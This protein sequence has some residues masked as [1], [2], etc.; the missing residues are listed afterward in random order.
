LPG[1]EPLQLS[2]VDH[3]GP[4]ENRDESPDRVD[5]HVDDVGIEHV[6]VRATEHDGTARRPLRDQAVA[7]VLDH[8]F[9]D[10]LVVAGRPVGRVDHR[11]IAARVADHHAELAGRERVHVL[12]V[13]V[14]QRRHW[15]RL[16]AHM[17][18]LADLGSEGD[19]EPH[20]LVS[21]GPDRTTT[22]P[23]RPTSR[24]LASDC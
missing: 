18:L 23:S 22:L 6:D 8:R 10:L 2:L 5:V 13:G 20:Q 19:G 7:H 9:S 14:G 12:V 3:S 11:R 21:R 16:V 15:H 17:P 24:V 1:F 4:V